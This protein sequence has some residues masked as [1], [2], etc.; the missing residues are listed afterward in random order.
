LPEE[1]EQVFPGALTPRE[2]GDLGRL[3]ELVSNA[4]LFS[5]CKEELG[6]FRM[7]EILGW[8][9][10]WELQG[11]QTLDELRKGLQKQGFLRN[12][13]YRAVRDVRKVQHRLL[14]DY[15]D[16]VREVDEREV[17][18]LIRRMAVSP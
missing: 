5:V 16:R 3:G 13:A 10:L 17:L 11:V 7:A 4:E 1:H 6:L 18:A 15:G 14:K 12:N 2:L 9:V 8:L